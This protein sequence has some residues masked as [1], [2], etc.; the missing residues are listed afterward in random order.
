[1]GTGG[2]VA[3]LGTNSAEEVEQKINSGDHKAREVYE[4]MACQI[5]KE[6]GA[7]A[8]VLKGKVDAIVITGGLAK[9]KMLMD[10][11]TERVKFI[12]Q[13]LIFTT[14]DEMKALAKGVVRILTG[15]EQR[16]TY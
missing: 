3:Y 11:I 15:K 9:S 10:W 8:T 1:M 13:V 7:M 4:A 16:K 14:D 12:A 6:I 2:L 5:S